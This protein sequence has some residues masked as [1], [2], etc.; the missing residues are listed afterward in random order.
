M[1]Y[2]FGKSHKEQKS[3]KLQK[4]L[5]LEEDKQ[6]KEELDRRREQELKDE[7]LAKELQ[8]QLEAEEEGGGGSAHIPSP[9]S[10][11]AS[12]PASAGPSAS[13]HV[14]SSPEPAFR[15]PPLPV[16]PV[17]Y[18]SGQPT[19]SSTDLSRQSIT[20]SAPPAPTS[21]ISV[22]AVPPPP[23]NT[24]PAIAATAPTLQTPRLPPR[25]HSASDL[26]RILPSHDSPRPQINL[27]Q[28]HHHHS[29]PTLPPSSSPSTFSSS[30]SA[31]PIRN[32]RES[33]LSHPPQESTSAPISTS[34]PNHSYALNAGTTYQHASPHL[35][36]SSSS[37]FSPPP[38]P[39]MRNDPVRM[40]VPPN[41]SMH[42]PPYPSAATPS[43]SHL[44]I[45]AMPQPSVIHKTHPQVDPPAR[46]A[47]L[48]TLERQT[49]KNT[50]LRRHQSKVGSDPQF[51]NSTRL[52]K[53]DE[54][55]SR[56][57][58]KTV[59]Y[60]K[61][62]D[63]S[64]SD[65]SGNLLHEKTNGTAMESES[66][67]NNRL[68]VP[69]TAGA[70]DEDSDA[71]DPFADSFAA[72]LSDV[73][74]DESEEAQPSVKMGSALQTDSNKW[75][76]D[77]SELLGSVSPLTENMQA[78]L[79]SLLKSSTIDPKRVAIQDEKTQQSEENTRRRTISLMTPH[80]QPQSMGVF[81]PQA[82]AQS[83][84]SYDDATFYSQPVYPTSFLRAG[85]PPALNQPPVDS[86]N[87]NSN[88]SATVE[89]PANEYGY[90]KADEGPEETGQETTINKTLPTLPK[91][92]RVW[93]R[94][95]PTDTGKSLA[96][97]IHVVATYQTR[98]ILKI[99]T[100]TGRLV[101]LDETPVFTD[102]SEVSRLNDGEPWRVE[103]GLMDNHLIDVFEG[104]KE[105]M[106]SLKASLRSEKEK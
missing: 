11:P 77:Q 56:N 61:E 79:A 64:D 70:D 104:G 5:Q 20:P 37:S 76:D 26:S 54:D 51:T 38:R 66:S 97:R 28:Q 82:A 86:N 57:E 46:L 98:K 9:V 17:A 36:A 92:Q 39:S 101:P 47:Q 95:H 78:R 91:S 8:A 63:G 50:E 103:W 45:M 14:D 62:E 49:V 44:P 99:Q 34:T 87:T 2:L 89:V 90:Y 85:A 73:E 3:V 71:G 80:T 52:Q 40:I 24:A 15:P 69:T 105:L 100:A 106:R 13:F 84:T 67:D 25:N 58:P 93:I 68:K 31:L 60:K 74:K 43:A 42:H 94:V 6:W 75:T 16:K 102:W 23:Y 96:Q 21:P 30:S 55:I 48:R 88:S 4:K 27:L 10:T 19:T 35:P 83:P 29:Q 33:Y 18:H 32:R 81:S 1:G 22:R 53:P 65:H 7:A 12:P 59:I 72:E 41:P